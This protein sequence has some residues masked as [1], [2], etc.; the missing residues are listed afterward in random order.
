MYRCNHCNITIPDNQTEGH[1]VK[2][3]PK[4]NPKLYCMECG[5][6]V[7]YI[8]DIPKTEGIFH[9][10]QATLISNS[11]NRITTNNYYGVMP[12]EQIETPYGLCR[13]NEARFCKQ[14]RQ[15]VPMPFFN[16]ERGICDN[17]I[18]NEG[19]K[20]FEDG[21]TFFEIGLYDEALSEF[22]KYEPICINKEILAKLQCYIG[23][24]FW[25]KKQWGDAFKYFI[26]SRNESADSRF[27]L[28]YCFLKGYGVE[29]DF[30]KAKEFFLCACRENDEGLKRRIIETIVEQANINAYLIAAELGDKQ[31]YE[32]MARLV[33]IN[34][35]GYLYNEIDPYLEAG[36][37]E[38][39]AICYYALA[40]SQQKRHDK[41]SNK[42]NI[43]YNYNKISQWLYKAASLQLADAAIELSKK[44]KGEQRIK[45]MQKTVELYDKQPFFLDHN[46]KDFSEHLF[47]LGRELNTQQDKTEATKWFLRAAELGHADAQATLGRIYY[48]GPYT[49]RDLN[50]AL[51]WTQEAANQGNTDALILLPQ[52]NID[53]AHNEANK[54]YNRRDYIHALDLYLKAA[55]LGCDKVYYD[56]GHMYYDGKGTAKNPSEALKWWKKAADM[57]SLLA[58]NNIATLYYDGAD[59]I[60]E[61]R[62][63]GKKW[64][65]KAADLGYM[66]AQG[67]LGLMYFNDREYTEAL[68]WFQ[69]S[70][71]KGYDFAQYYLGR[72]YHEGLGVNKSLYMAREWLN[73]AA[74]QGNQKAK[75]L[76]AKL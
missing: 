52:I 51:H 42:N 29:Q 68:K 25:E 33:I 76:L 15:W 22:L 40:Y 13:K 5:E 18:Q 50:K 37:Q 44:L 72:M 73:K 71:N 75:D 62:M 7:T 2:V 12:D 49:L 74:A 23:R 16:F 48:T 4:A 9:G 60:P 24:C 30:R 61:N 64:M 53:Y 43:N 45:W 3:G 66:V 58:M 56:I 17:C 69:M 10:A 59:G 8:P 19:T 26:K 31:H 67:N 21:K 57:G 34:E 63:E 39:S 28:G 11:D 47:Q 35:D 54:F 27:Y 46:E 41:G 70:A 14:C 32:D 6:P 55:S 1:I 20:A 65:R 38:G 36:A